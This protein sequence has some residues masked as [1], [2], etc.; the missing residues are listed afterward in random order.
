MTMSVWPLQVFFL[1][2]LLYNMFCCR[3][4]VWKTPLKTALVKSI[5]E[6]DT[7][8]WELG[9]RKSQKRTE[10][11]LSSY[12]T[13]LRVAEGFLWELCKMSWSFK[14]L[15]DPLLFFLSILD[16]SVCISSAWTSLM[17]N[18]SSSGL[19]ATAISR[20]TGR[21]GERQTQEMNSAEKIGITLEISSHW[22]FE[23]KFELDSVV[24]SSS[25]ALGTT[26]WYFPLV[27]ETPAPYMK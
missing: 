15:V 14:D 19:A 18:K 27:Y 6:T 9:I 2:L 12:I 26:S 3:F 21:G 20:L 25:S 7:M 8:V 17:E 11:D 4:V 13:D 16:R 24:L 22:E 5:V 1:V 23:N 10:K